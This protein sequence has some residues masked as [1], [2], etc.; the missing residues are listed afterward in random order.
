MAL[1]LMDLNIFQ[2]KLDAVLSILYQQVGKMY[3]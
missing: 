3:V 1:K 2:I